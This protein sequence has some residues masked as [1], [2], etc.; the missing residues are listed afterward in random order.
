VQ[1]FIPNQ[2]I[3]VTGLERTDIIKAKQ[4]T[5][6]QQIIFMSLPIMKNAT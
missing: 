4:K 2:N 1:A 3:Q 5:H 6:I